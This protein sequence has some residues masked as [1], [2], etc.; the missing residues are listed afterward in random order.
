MQY[1]YEALKSRPTSSDL[2]GVNAFVTL[3]KLSL[4]VFVELVLIG[5]L[6]SLGTTRIVKW[7]GTITNAFYLKYLI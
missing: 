3:L 4:H 1:I 6:I 2:T 5:L 7:T